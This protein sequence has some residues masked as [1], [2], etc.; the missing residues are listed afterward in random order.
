MNLRLTNF[1]MSL[2]DECAKMS[3][4]V[5]LQVGAVI[6]KDDNIL[7]FGWNGTPKGWSNI[8]EEKH[9]CPD[10]QSL[11]TL[12]NIVEYPSEGHYIDQ[13]GRELKG[14]YRLVTKPEVLHAE[15]NALMKLTK[16]THSSDNASIFVTHAPCLECAKGIYQS[17]IKHL[18]YRNVY[19]TDHGLN[20][21][22][23]CEVSVSK[24]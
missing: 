20:F 15:M 13:Q 6:I 1:Y 23:Q 12:E 3:R 4:A 2:A 9:W 5:R 11:D 24:I 16:S 14:R 19:R 17:G 7:S 18:Y 22:K 10:T 8:C 21:L